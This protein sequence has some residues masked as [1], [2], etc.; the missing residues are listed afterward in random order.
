MTHPLTD[1]KCQQIW[2]DYKDNWLKLQEPCP[3]TRRVMRAAADRQLE[4]VIEWLDENLCNYD[5]GTESCT[6]FFSPMSRLTVDL[7]KAMRPTTQEDS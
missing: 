3:A 7:A 4:Q 2:E 5:R 6:G 1:A